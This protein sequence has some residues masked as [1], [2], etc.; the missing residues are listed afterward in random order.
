MFLLCLKAKT[1]LSK[2]ILSSDQL[3]RDHAQVNSFVSNSDGVL[4][5]AG[6]RTHFK[7][8]ILLNTTTRNLE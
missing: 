3:E 4:N 5:Q 6:G 2:I 7:S 1:S 8:S